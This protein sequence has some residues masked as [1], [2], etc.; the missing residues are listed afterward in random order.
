MK[1]AMDQEDSSEKQKEQLNAVLDAALDAL[2]DDDEQQEPEDAKRPAEQ[3]V[4]PKDEPCKQKPIYGPEKPPEFDIGSFDAVMK[5]MFSGAEV[6]GDP[7]AGLDFFMQQLQSQLASEFENIEASQSNPASPATSDKTST[8]KASPSAERPLSDTDDKT[9]VDRTISKL[10]ND[11]A[12]ANVSDNAGDL[13][14]G[15]GEEAMFKDMMKEFENMAGGGLNQD[16]ILDGMM[17]QLV[18]KDIMY[19]PMKQ[20]TDR[21]PSWLEENK[22]NLSEEEFQN[23][24]KQYKCFQ[25]LIDVY[26]SEPANVKKLMELMQDVQEYGQPP[27]DIIKEIAPGLDLDEEGV[28]KL[29]GMGGFTFG[30]ENEECNIM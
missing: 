25:K 15:G 18:S 17:Q 8:E 4:T 12:T 16:A 14:E 20:V 9:N 13:P 22:D 23:R 30:E 26:E 3:P 29:D 2:D 1:T 28:P 19:E 10:L 27:P 7:E 5:Q 21:F 6:G 11:M 24:S